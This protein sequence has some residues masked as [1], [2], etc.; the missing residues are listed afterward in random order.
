M[1]TRRIEHTFACDV[2]TYWT[3]FFLDEAFNKKLFLDRL[4]F[5]KWVL[6]KQEP[7][8]DGARRVVEAAPSTDDIPGPLKKLLAGGLGYREEGEWFQSQSRYVVRVTPNSLP[9][10]MDIRGEMRVVADDAGCRRIYD[11]DVSVRVF[12]VGGL[13]EGRIL[14]DVVKSYEA[15]AV[16]TREALAHG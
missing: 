6:V 2:D 1:A 10:K 9:D 11:A 7:S 5:S 3:R 13:L 14:D 15:A 8:G 12:G 16:F 4:G